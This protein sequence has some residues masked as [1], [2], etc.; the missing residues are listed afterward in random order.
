MRRVQCG[1][2]GMSPPVG[3]S[4]GCPGAVRFPQPMRRPVL[5]CVHAAYAATE[6]GAGCF[7]SFCAQQDTTR[8]RIAMQVIDF[9]DDKEAFWRAYR[10]KG[11]RRRK[12]P[13]TTTTRAQRGEGNRERALDRLARA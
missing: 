4:P 1:L 8:S 13:T 11:K 7:A 9:G 5:R 12:R 2:A 3:A 10:G 6:P